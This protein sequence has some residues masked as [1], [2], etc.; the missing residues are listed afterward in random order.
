[1]Q[2]VG[3]A[4]MNFSCESSMLLNQRFE[5]ILLITGWNV[6]DHGSNMIDLGDNLNENVLV[7]VSHLNRIKKSA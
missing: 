1:M 3:E 7:V 5:Q 4:F 6:K 2:L